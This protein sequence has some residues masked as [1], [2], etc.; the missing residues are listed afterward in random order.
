MEWQTTKNYLFLNKYR[1]DKEAILLLEG[2]SRSGKTFDTI[3]FFISHCN[4][5]IN[6]G[7]LISWCRSTQIGVKSNILP[8][9]MRICDMLGLKRGN[10]WNYS[11]MHSSFGCPTITLFGN[12]IR[13]YGMNSDE[14]LSKLHG[15][16]SDM[17]WC[18]EMVNIDK[19]AVEQLRIRLNGLFIGDYNP[20][21]LNSYVYDMKAL[22]E[23]HWI[24]T[25]VLDN[26]NA[27][28]NAVR[29]IMRFEPTPENIAL[30]T[31]DA[32]KW[33]IYGLGIPGMSDA[34][35]FKNWELF[36]ENYCE[37]GRFLY[38][39]CEHRVWGMDFGWNDKTA[40]VFARIDTKR[41]HAFIWE[42]FGGSEL[43]NHN[44]VELFKINGYRNYEGSTYKVKDD[45]CV[46]DC[47][48]PRSLNEIHRLG[49]G[50]LVPADKRGKEGDDGAEFAIKK[51]QEYSIFIEKN[52]RNLQDEFRGYRWKEDKDGNVLRGVL[53]VKSGKRDHFIDATK[54]IFSTF[55]REL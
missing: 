33:N 34:T 48:D 12:Y 1:F 30:K 41:K 10:H 36:D 25:T 8:D 31:A 19:R 54:Y 38:S 18:N 37:D 26:K 23:C 35:I 22:P 42:K 44:I 43:F 7:L 47:A 6:K 24:R 13:F 49:I 32:V 4:I 51:M 16:Y 40:C 3:F 55:F 45:V 9:F 15:L 11:P 53:S 28:K 20:S 27:P 14:D 21:E 29:E 39:D 52:S 17:A 50:G 46:C 5:H 2:G